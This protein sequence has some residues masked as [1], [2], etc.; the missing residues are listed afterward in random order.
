VGIP[1]SLF[2]IAGGAIV[3]FA[4]TDNANGIN[5]YAVGWILMVAGAVLLVLSLIMWDSWAGGGYWHRRTV[6]RRPPPYEPP[7]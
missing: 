3:A 2:L 6:A 4:V 1:L 7:Y 5:L